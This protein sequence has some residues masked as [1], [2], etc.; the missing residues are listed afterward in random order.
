MRDRHVERCRLAMADGSWWTLAELAEEIG[1]SEAAASARVRDLRKNA[2]G[3]HEVLCR[4]TGPGGLHRYRLVLGGE[5]N[6]VPA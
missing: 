2:Y 4:H 1:C 6:N 5:A 3:S